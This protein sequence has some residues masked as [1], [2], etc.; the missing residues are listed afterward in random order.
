MNAGFTCA[1][2]IDRDELAVENHR[3]NLGVPTLRAD[4]SQ[5]TGLPEIEPVDVLIAG[6]PCQGFSTLGGGDPK[7]PRNELLQVPALMAARLKPQVVVIENVFGATSPGN[8]RHV[9]RVC[10]GL[11]G[12][13]YHV[14]TVDV[15]MRDLGLAQRRRRVLLI[16]WRTSS[17]FNLPT[18]ALPPVSLE[19]VLEGACGFPNHEP[20]VPAVGSRGYR[21][22]RR[23]PPGKKLCNVRVSPAAVRTWDIPD[24]FG[25]T[26][27]KERHVLESLVRLRR[28]DRRRSYGDADP[29]R[30][31]TVTAAVGFPAAATL[32]ALT[33]KRF[34][35]K[36]GG[37]YDLVH[38]FNGKYRRPDPSGLAPAV[39][40]RFGDFR[41]VLH[42]HEDRAFSAR[43]A[44]RIQGF[45][46]S[47]TFSGARRAQMRLIANAVPPPAA[48]RIATAV[49]VTLEH[50]R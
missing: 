7:D 8:V 37:F 38:T 17:E 18:A 4:L 47:F 46:D 50:A 42:P 23:I 36:T 39:D 10:A 1:L 2:A 43:E 30:S 49:R 45:P 25:S 5:P 12:S 15:D 34:V 24:V 21:I 22:A 16:A 6:P 9:D 48:E 31:R 3:R 32:A 41:Y 44:A 20:A 27:E 35:R 11:V 40:S 19:S 28:R 26:T 29:V 13:G 14:R 33:R